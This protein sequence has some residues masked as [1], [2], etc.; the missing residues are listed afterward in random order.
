[1]TFRIF[2]VWIYLEL[3]ILGVLNVSLSK[4]DGMAISTGAGCF[5]RSFCFP[6]VRTTGLCP[7]KQLPNEVVTGFE[8]LFTD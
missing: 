3:S 5:V 2:F 4:H 8:F 1:M 7:C 6:A